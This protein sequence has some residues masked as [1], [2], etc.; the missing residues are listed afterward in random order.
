[1]FGTFL[2]LSFLST[3]G[4]GHSEEVVLDNNERTQVVRQIAEK[5]TKNYVFQKLAEKTATFLTQ[6]LKSG[7][8]DNLEDGELFAAKLTEDLQSVNQDKHMRVWTRSA[9]QLHRE[10]KDPLATRIERNRFPSEDN[11]GFKRVERLDGNVGYL[12]FR[13][14]DKS[15]AAKE[16]A[17]AAFKFLAN[18][19]SLIIDMRK[20]RGGS[21]VMVQFICSYL[22][23][24]KIHLN[25]LYWREGD[26]TDEFW[27]L[28]DLP[29]KRMPEVPVYV[30]TSNKTFSGAEEFSYN[31]KTR[32]RAIIVGETTGGG[33]N[34]GRSFSLNKRFRMVIPTGRAINPVTGIS[35][36][37]TG[38]LPDIQATADE[39]FDK[40]YELAKI[41]AQKFRQTVIDEKIML[42]KNL[43]KSF[44]AVEQRA[45]E[46]M[47][48]AQ[49]LATI[50]LNKAILDK[51]GESEIN[52]FGY[53]YLFEKKNTLVAIL[54][55]KFITL[56]FP[57]SANS[58]DSLGDAYLEQGNK[59]LARLNYKKSL[60]LNPKNRHAKRVLSEL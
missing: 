26:R 6:Q 32:K 31:L 33:A 2:F 35:W 13:V 4:L 18:S 16:V 57:N 29:G 52:D 30:L 17:A 20:N 27:T 46:D 51:L 60:E 28:E 43:G 3:P 14:F 15:A 9:K 36:E 24:S 50:V 23:K 37:G 8:Y 25:S 42:V 19:D 41:S 44:I 59:K 58:Y 34:P 7:H 5:V 49:Q 10:V 40:A 56:S 48:K 11:Y 22:F 54:I 21:P 45:I 47:P 53:D 38:V 1:M 12:D 55:F 39:A